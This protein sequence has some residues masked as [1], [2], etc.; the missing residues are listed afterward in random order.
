MDKNLL[1]AMRSGA[2]SLDLELDDDDELV[3][4]IAREDGVF[5]ITL[6]KIIRLRSPS[7]LY[8][9]LNYDAVPLEKSLFLPHGAA[10]PLV[11]RTVIQTARMA[12]LFFSKEE[13]KYNILSDI[14]WELMRSVVSLRFIKDRLEGQTNEIV[15]IIQKDMEAYT[16]GQSPKTL[17]II[18]YYDIEFR[19][20]VNEVRRGLNAVS[21]LFFPL[22]GVKFS[23]GHFHRA[24]EWAESTLGQGSDLAQMLRRDQRWIATWI[25]IRT[26]I[27]HPKKDKFVETLNFSL[28]PGR[29]IRLPTWRFVHPDYDMNRPQNLLTVLDICIN[30]ILKFYEDI[31]VVLIGV[32]LSKTMHFLAEVIPEDQRDP[33]LPFRYNFTRFN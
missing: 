29:T 27:E 8:P 30:N 17:P 11:A 31:Q 13:K 7:E 28:E 23:S 21:E 26:A 24:Q 14:S 16:I 10:D 25:D 12:G 33:K 1:K 15:T 20:F 2:V 9:D 3:E 18:E 5:F 22:I 19:S 32:H 6:K 4:T